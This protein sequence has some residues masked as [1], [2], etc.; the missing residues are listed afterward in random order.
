MIYILSGDT[1]EAL[2]CAIQNGLSLREWRDASDIVDNSKGELWKFGS[3]FVNPAYY[4]IH[5]MSA[6]AGLPEINKNQ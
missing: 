1:D 3:Y 5:K 6:T 2:I 4:E